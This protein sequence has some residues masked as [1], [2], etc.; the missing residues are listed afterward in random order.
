MPGA[1]PGGQ[2]ATRSML[3]GRCHPTAISLTPLPPLLPEE[4]THSTVSGADDEQ[5]AAP[6]VERQHG[7]RLKTK[8]LCRQQHQRCDSTV[9][10]LMLGTA[11][12]HAGASSQ[13]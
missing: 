6:G 2:Q 10:S 11:R 5:L 8:T 3:S 7:G 12:G 1:V 4:G 9:G 13:R